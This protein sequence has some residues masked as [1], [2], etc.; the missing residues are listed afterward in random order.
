MWIVGE[1]RTYAFAFLAGL[2]AGFALGVHSVKAEELTR[3]P[4]KWVDNA[5]Y[6]IIINIGGKPAACVIDTGA[7]LTAIGNKFF[8]SLET[9]EYIVLHEGNTQLANGT[10]VPT[11]YIITH[12]DMVTS[13]QTFAMPTDYVGNGHDCLLG[14]SWLRS[15][16]SFGFVREHD[17]ETA[18]LE[19]KR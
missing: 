2:F 17:G 18:I 8:Q 14:S 7:T 6:T 1:P 9:N 13:M 19:L 3:L 16:K 10:L 4:I 5:G 11:K 12:T 15:F